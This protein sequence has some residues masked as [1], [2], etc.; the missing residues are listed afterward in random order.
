MQN[1]TTDQ[2][3]IVVDHVPCYDSAS[4]RPGIFKY[5]IITFNADIIFFDTEISVELRGFRNDLCIF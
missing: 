3:Y 1:D 5:G 4:S 2:L